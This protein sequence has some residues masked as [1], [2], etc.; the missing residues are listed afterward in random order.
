VAGGVTD[1][2]KRTKV[3]LTRVNGQ[4]ITVNYDKAL[5]K[6]ELDPPVYPGDRI[7]VARRV[8]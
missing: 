6:P 7:Y 2:A 3:Q 8:I 4:R 5:R 1:F